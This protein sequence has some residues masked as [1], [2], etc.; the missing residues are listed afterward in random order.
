[1]ARLKNGPYG[2]LMG[3]LGNIVNYVR[4]GENVARMRPRKTA[5]RR[6]KATGKLAD[7]QARF[8]MAQKYVSPLKD[9]VC[10]SFHPATKGTTKIPQNAATSLFREHAIMGEHPNLWI[11]YSRVIVSEGNLPEPQNAAV[12]FEDNVLTFTWDVEASLSY[13]RK[14]DQ[15]MVL[16]YLPDTMRAFFIVGGAR[17]TAGTEQLQID[18]R[19]PK[20]WHT[21]DTVVETYVAFISNDRQ[22]VSD[23]VYCGQISL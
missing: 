23:S 22:R 8:R 10:Y 21:A 3:L 20:P 15:V 17:R 4:R 14:S 19:M 2:F 1:M 12:S 18:P 16:A 5:K 13:A 7:S 9:F 11:D 6:K